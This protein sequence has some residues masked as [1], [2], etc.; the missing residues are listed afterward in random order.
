MLSKHLFRCHLRASHERSHRAEPHVHRHSHK[1]YRARLPANCLS[2]RRP[3]RCGSSQRAPTVSRPSPVAGETRRQTRHTFT[4]Q[5]VPHISIPES[6]RKRGTKLRWSGIL[7]RFEGQV[8]PPTAVAHPADCPARGSDPAVGPGRHPGDSNVHGRRLAADDG[9]QRLSGDAGTATCSAASSS[10]AAACLTAAGTVA[11][12]QGTAHT[13]S[14]PPSAGLM[15]ATPGPDYLGSSADRRRLTLCGPPLSLST[16][17]SSG[18][19][20]DVQ[21]QPQ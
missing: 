12:K 2:L 14:D 3:P 13:D 20:S 17:H 7:Y 10:H 16:P 15:A 6:D 1:R 21:Q 9:G 18:V 11:A 5:R 19:R 8:S 4:V